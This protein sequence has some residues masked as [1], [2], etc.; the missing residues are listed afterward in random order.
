MA[1]KGRQA[2]RRAGDDA[3]AGESDRRE[4]AAAV[5]ERGQAG[6]VGGCELM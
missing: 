4:A 3:A 1:G 5:G 2:G 6:M